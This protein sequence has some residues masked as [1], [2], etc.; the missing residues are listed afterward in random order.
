MGTILG[1]PP[2]PPPPDVPQLEDAKKDGAPKTL[3][4]MLEIHRKNPECASCHAKTDPL[5]FG[6]ENFDAIGRWVE[7]QEGKPIDA[8]GVLPN[9]E[10]FNGPVEM[11]KI[12]D[13]RKDDF[14]RGLTESLLIYALGRGLIHQDE[15]VVRASLTALQKDRYRFSAL[16]K[17]I[18][19]SYPFT[20]RRNA[21]F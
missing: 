2:P 17:T 10:S 20:H 6:L 1:I 14:A 21:E 8:S 12:M 18:V 13:N 4:E 3:R 11:K 7:T 19:T 16:V 15:C 9:G 5:G